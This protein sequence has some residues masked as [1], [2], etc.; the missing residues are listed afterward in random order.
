MNLKILNKP[1]NCNFS[2][3]KMSLNF[4]GTLKKG[5]SKTAILANLDAD[6]DYNDDEAPNCGNENC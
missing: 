1:K 3:K 5:V 6:S 2:I 4:E